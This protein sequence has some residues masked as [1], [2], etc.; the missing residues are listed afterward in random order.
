MSKIFTRTFR[1]RWGELDP[2]GTV[3]PANYLRYLSETAWDWGEAIGLG[4]SDSE[5]L[6]MFWVIRE[7]EL[8]FLHPLRHNDV[9]GL[10]IWLANWQRVRGT[11]CFELKLKA[12]GEV[13][14]Q[15][16][17]QVVCMDTKTGRPVSLTEDVIDRFRLEDPPVFPSERFPKITAPVNPFVMQRQVESM[18]LDVYDHVNNAIYLDYATEATAQDF[19]VRGWSPAKLAAA[20]LTL[21]IRR[22]QILYSS[23][24]LWGETLNISTYL[25]ELKETG[26][27]RYVGMTRADGS[28]VA[29]CI[30]DWELVDGTR[31][32]AQSLPDELR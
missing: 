1:V 29:E 26:G 10:T 21:A 12:S 2:S 18:D 19:S 17:Q 7:T 32:E 5:T 27:S 8:R 14:A 15:G 11:R 20:N 16:T 23:Q 28:P 6:G 24:A 30:M 22:V 4:V 9:F 13:I 25:L 3:G 31:G